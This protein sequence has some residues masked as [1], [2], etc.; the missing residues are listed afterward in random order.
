M[1]GAVNM[2][3]RKSL[4]SQ[5]ALV[6]YRRWS[7]G[8]ASHTNSKVMM[9]GFTLIELLI[10]IGILAALAA[11]ILLVINPAQLIKQSRDAN[12]I[13][14]LNQID[15][16]LSIFQSFGG[17]SMGTHTNV[18]IS[19]PSA[20]SDCGYSTGNP[21]SLPTLTDP[22]W[23]YVCS[24]SVNY[25]KING[26]G[27]IPVDF[28]SVQSSAG[29][30]FSS[31]PID[32]INTVANGYYYTYVPGSWALSA[33]MESEKYITENAASD[34]GKV[35]KRFELGN[36]IDLNQKLGTD[37]PPVC[38]N[39]LKEAGEVCDGSDLNAKTCA[40]Q[41][42]A[43]HTGTLSC[44]TNCSDF[45]SSACVAPIYPIPTN[46]LVGYWRFQ[47]NVLDDTVNNNNG[48]INGTG[49]TYINRKVGNYAI[50]FDGNHNSVAIPHSAS[51]NISGNAMTTMFWIKFTSGS[52]PLAKWS[53]SS[54]SWRID[55]SFSSGP[56]S[57]NFYIASPVG[58]VSATNL[59]LTNDAWHYVANVYNGSNIMTYIDGELAG[60]NAASGNISTSTNNICIGSLSN[61][62]TTCNSVWDNLTGSIDEVA[63]YNVALSA[64]DILAIYNGQK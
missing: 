17:T 46:G 31:L 18:Y 19:I 13:T 11:V 10:V 40:T 14:E 37:I 64:Q 54:Y 51:L 26:T 3:F 34:G 62:G 30:I 8:S 12:R 52:F 39:N 63:I 53:D 58:N 20:D 25:R 61:S 35:P 60:T 59:T 32:P 27:W 55:Y 41:F 2:N 44:K 48:V 7:A 45:V 24:N 9:R 36:N 16:A 1:A 38:G 56:N 49:V 29:T 6:S 33:T 4:F 47:N 50:S 5:K 57:L 15:K 42:G 22:N 23:H 21:L 28:T 43:G